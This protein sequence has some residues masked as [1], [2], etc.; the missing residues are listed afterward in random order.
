MYECVFRGE[1]IG[2]AKKKRFQCRKFGKCTAGKTRSGRLP[3]CGECVD[4][5]VRS[6]E[7]F[8]EKWIDPLLVTSSSGMEAEAWEGMLKGQPS[9]L[10]CGGPSGKDKVELLNRR[11]TFS[12]A[13]NNAAGFGVRPQAFVCSDPPLKFTHSVWL[14]PGVMKFVPRPKVSKSTRGMIRRKYNGNTFVEHGRTIEVPN[15]WRFKRNSW[16]RPDDSFFTDQGAAWGNL[17]SGVKRTGE[18]K[19]VSTMLLGLRLLYYLGSRRVYLVGVDF[20]MK[21][22]EVYSFNQGKGE[23]GCK[24]NNHQYEVLNKW[25]VRM[26]STGVFDR[27]GLEVFNCCQYSGLR[28]FPFVDFDAAVDDAVGWVEKVPDLKGWYEKC[29]C[30][31][32]ESWHVQMDCIIGEDKCL[33]CGLT[34][35]R[36]RRSELKKEYKRKKGKREEK[37]E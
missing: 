29:R 5:L 33:D 21:P 14:D 25:L 18:E 36:E 13:V 23:G 9:F 24:S 3:W 8:K 2:K 20:R 32:C 26:Q 4:R 7:D 16:F 17:D 34:W 1:E 35:P 28:A 19:T 37:D 22:G 6:D 10:V 27:F 30:P 15:V 11:G 12:L 31:K